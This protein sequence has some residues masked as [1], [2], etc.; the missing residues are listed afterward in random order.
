MLIHT[1]RYTGRGWQWATASIYICRENFAFARLGTWA[2]VTPRLGHFIGTLKPTRR[3]FVLLF[4]LKVVFFDS[5]WYWGSGENFVEM[6][7]FPIP[8]NYRCSNSATVSRHFVFATTVKLSSTVLLQFKMTW[9]ESQIPG[10]DVFQKCELLEII[11]ICTRREIDHVSFLVLW[12]S[13]TAFIYPRPLPELSSGVIHI[14]LRHD[15]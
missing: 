5:L 11:L 3:Q 10:Q 1:F 9:P 13:I 4:A 15:N 12:I 6:M 8:Y 7:A 2:H 14:N